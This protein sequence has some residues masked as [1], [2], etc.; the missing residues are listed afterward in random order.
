MKGNDDINFDNLKLS[1]CFI[2]GSHDSGTYNLRLDL[3]TINP[4]G[5]PT[6]LNPIIYKWSVCQ[7]KSITEQLQFGVRYFDLRVRKYDERRMTEREQNND[8]EF[9]NFYVVHGLTG[10]KIIDI[11]REFK[12]FINQNQNEIIIIDINHDHYNS[13]NQTY[14]FTIEDQTTFKRL[15]NESFKND[16]LSLDE[17]SNSTIGEIH[18]LNKH[19]Y[20]SYREELNSFWPNENKFENMKNKLINHISQHDLIMTRLHVD[21]CILTPRTKNVLFNYS[22]RSY[23]QKNTNK[24]K[25]FIDNYKRRFNILLLD[26]INEEDYGYI[27]NMIKEEN[28]RR[29][30]AK[31]LIDSNKL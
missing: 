17:V 9:N 28:I 4:E 11:F 25:T 12:N 27:I 24:F 23:V 21:Q 30:E 26:F 20:V 18:K 13:D 10:N 14:N 6:F 19:F 3:K 22:L 1:E 31:K 2:L 5:L 16:L 29:G 8:E 7:T 15:I